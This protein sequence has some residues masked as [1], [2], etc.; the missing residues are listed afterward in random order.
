M[1][2]G[3]MV[4]SRRALVHGKSVTRLWFSITHNLV[5][6][7]MLVCRSDIASAVDMLKAGKRMAD[8]LDENPAVVVKF[9]RGLMYAGMLLAKPRDPSVS[10]IIEIYW[11]DSGTGKT[12][13]AIDENEDSYLLTK[14]NGNNTVWFD[15]YEG[16][17]CVILD[18]FYGWVQYDLL[19]R[20]LD[21]YPLKVQT[22]GGFVEMCA[23]KFVI[24]SNKQWQDWYPN[25]DDKSALDRRIRE[26][27]RVTHFTK[28]ELVDRL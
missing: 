27:G 26:F 8:V 9:H 7:N 21:R 19:L 13:K 1:A 15:G 6:C 23:T 18:E 25:V 16:Q 10:P 12:R 14:P 22:K 24:T 20:L 5:T 17:K 3:S 2:R 4:R 11:G 28:M